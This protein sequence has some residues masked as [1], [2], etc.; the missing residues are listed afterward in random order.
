MIFDLMSGMAYTHII[1]QSG[2]ETDLKI[3]S[4]FA[5]YHLQDFN[6]FLNRRHSPLQS[7]PQVLQYH[8]VMPSHSSRLA[9]MAWPLL[10]EC[11]SDGVMG[12][13]TTG[14]T[15]F[16]PHS[17]QRRGRAGLFVL[18]VFC[19]TFCSYQTRRKADGEPTASFAVPSPHRRANAPCRL[20][21]HG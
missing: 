13:C 7:Q 17:G 16:P 18:F 14:I 15:L 12:P 3:W 20:Q 19:R 5:G 6:D 21:D 8:S 10:M 11:R 4:G 1:I 2:A 9:R